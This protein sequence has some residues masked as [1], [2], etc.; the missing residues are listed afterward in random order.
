MLNICFIHIYITPADLVR[1]NHN[2]ATW[3]AILLGGLP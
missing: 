2:M 3:T 1:Y